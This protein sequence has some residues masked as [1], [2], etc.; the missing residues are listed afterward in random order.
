MGAGGLVMVDGPAG[1]G[2][3]A[4]LAAARAAAAEAGLL[5]LRARG[6]ELEQEFG[7]GVVR[8][9]FEDVARAE[10][11]TGAAR[12][13]APLLG[14][15]LDGAAAPEDPFAARHALYWLTANLAA[16]R[17]L[18]LVVDD[19][20]WADAASLG[21]LAHIANRAAGL[22]VA[23]IAASRVEQAR[24]PLDAL[25]AQA[26]T[27]L[28][29]AP[30]GLEAATA[31]LRAVAPAADDAL[32]RACHAATGGNPFLLGELVRSLLDGAVP[33]ER[34]GEQSPERVTREIAARLA[35][36]P[37]DAR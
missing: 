13:A 27:M 18:A 29:V 25:R 9:L 21:V 35:R 28:H 15:E 2:K 17:P 26:E 7:Y 23:L 14:L 30:L 31:V 34:V 3:T 12:F 24:P 22:P 19:A 32:C 16:E 10:L 36:L 5:V 33:A 1:V 11:F 8:Q 20:H 6:A 37:P 4:L